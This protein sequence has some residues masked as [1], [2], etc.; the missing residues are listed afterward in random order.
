[1][2]TCVE[3][4]LYFGH[5][6]QAAYLFLWRNATGLSYILNAYKKLNSRRKKTESCYAVQVFEYLN[7][8]LLETS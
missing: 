4:L 5:K 6:L 1:M 3:V 2:R 8:V 7:Q